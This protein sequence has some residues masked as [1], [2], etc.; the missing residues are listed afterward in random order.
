MELFKETLSLFPPPSCLLLGWE[1]D[2]EE[3]RGWLQR[4]SHPAGCCPGH[5][6]VVL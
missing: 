3:E 2:E 4:C 1:E 5:G 6:D